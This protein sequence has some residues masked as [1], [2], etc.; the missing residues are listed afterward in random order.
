MFVLSMEMAPVQVAQSHA[1][2]YSVVRSFLA[3]WP[4]FHPLTFRFAREFR[5]FPSGLQ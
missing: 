4:T 2:R 1:I 3:I 5:S